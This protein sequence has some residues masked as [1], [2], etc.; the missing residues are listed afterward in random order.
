MKSVKALTT[1][2]G[3]ALAG[4]LLF[5]TY[6]A[7]RKGKNLVTV[8]RHDSL[9]VYYPNYT[10]IDLATGTIPST[11]DKSIIF[12]CSGA[13]TAQTLDE[14]KHSNIEGHHVSSGK[15]YQGHYCKANNGVFTWSA[16]TGGRFFHYT[17]KNSEAPLKTAA[18]EGG[19][20]FC[21]G[22]L[23]HNGKQLKGCF[24]ANAVHRYRALCEIGGRLCI[25]DCARSLRFDCFM[26]A[27]KKLGV[28]NAIYCDMGG[29]DYSWYRQDDGKVNILFS[30]SPSEYATNWVVFYSDDGI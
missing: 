14:F 9:T 25:V 29:W 27:L 24:K 18:K 13:F 21:Q 11:S 30:T 7:A 5:P 22:L 23:F 10:R 20:G 12:L 8:E 4:F 19:M 1:A 2:A 16:K 6:S 26:A 15:F 17:H 28:K 3:L